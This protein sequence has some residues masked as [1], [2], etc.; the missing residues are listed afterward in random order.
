M[1]SKNNGS[2]RHRQR[3]EYNMKMILTLI[4]SDLNESSQL[5]KRRD[6]FWDGKRKR[7]EKGVRDKEGVY[8][9]E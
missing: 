7:K 8:T 2:S 5:N 4:V 9:A 1:G 6:G 3:V